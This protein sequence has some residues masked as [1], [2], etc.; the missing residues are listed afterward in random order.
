MASK[1]TTSKTKSNTPKR[2]IYSPSK[3]QQALDAIHKGRLLNKIE[4]KSPVE[5][6][7]H[8]GVTSILGDE[9]EALLVEWMLTCAKMGFPVDREELLSSVKKLV[10]ELEM[11]TPFI[12]N[13]PGKKWFYGFMN[14]HKC[15]S[16]KHSEYVNKAKGSVTEEK[17]RKWFDEVSELLGE[18]LYVLNYPERVFNMDETC[19][20]LAPKGELILGPRGCNVYDEQTNNNK[21]N[22]TTLF[23]ANALGWGLGKSEN[24]WMTAETFFEYMANIFLPHLIQ[25]NISR[26]VIIFLD[27]HSSHLSLH[28]SKFCRE[29]GLILIA[30]YPNSTHILQPLDV[31][32]FG[33]LKSSWK[34]T[35]KQW[36]IDNDR[37]ISKFDMPTALSNIMNTPNI[38]KNVQSGFRST[39]LLPFNP[40][41]VDFTKVIIRS[42]PT[43]QN[44]SKNNE[45]QLHLKFIEKNTDSNLLKEFKRAYIGGYEWDGDIK[46]TM[47]FN[48]WSTCVTQT[49][50]EKTRTESIS[51]ATTFDSIDSYMSPTS[52]QLTTI[53]LESTTMNNSSTSCQFCQLE[54][55]PSTSHDSPTTL[56]LP[57]RRSLTSV[58]EDVIKWPVQQVSKSKRKREYTPSIIT[59]D[60]WVQFHELKEADKLK[61]VEEREN[62]RKAIQDRKRVAEEKKGEHSETNQSW[63]SISHH[64]LEEPLAVPIQ[65]MDLVLSTSDL[66]PASVL[67]I[68]DVNDIEIQCFESIDEE[69]TEFFPIDN[70]VSMIGIESIVGKLPVPELKL[71]GRQLKS[72]FP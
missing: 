62:K 26:P 22:I 31:A 64:S 28:L 41:N 1:P 18:N 70:D 58:F 36:R 45:I 37:E 8:G 46:A 68:A 33:P 20:Y 52:A 50:N 16:Q 40:N 23:A 25:S 2:C 72:V 60:R 29:N 55:Q 49:N 12:N 35:V 61:K 66:K 63:S 53:S 10:D 13:R 4:G 38:S 69:N 24:G 44:T 32:V 6:V 48:L 54:N 67:K 43:Q 65:S 51:Q 17:I 71:S 9:T 3:V 59:S 27:G 39:G 5:S 7:G 30:L 15:L 56:I 21:E 57:T 34:K 11:K 19:F 14:R 47:L 42:V